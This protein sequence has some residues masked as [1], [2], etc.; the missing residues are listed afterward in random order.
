MNMKP[1][2]LLGALA[3]LFFFPKGLLAQQA[4]QQ[5]PTAGCRPI[6]QGNTFIEPDEQIVGDQ[7]CK[8]V[9]AAQPAP[10]AEPTKPPQQDSSSTV[11]SKG[12]IAVEPVGSHAFRNIMLAGVAGAVISKEQY[13]VLAVKDYPTHVGE[14]FHGGDLQTIQNN[15]TKVVMLDKHAKPE[16]AANASK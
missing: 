9:V 3:S 7:V 10:V 15:G 2:L 11:Q 14:K 5:R 1:Y 8:K 12:C 4:T 6:S 16:D 13:K